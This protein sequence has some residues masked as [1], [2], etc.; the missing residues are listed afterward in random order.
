MAK[1]PTPHGF[2][3][4]EEY[5]GYMTCLS[6]SQS[7]DKAW[8]YTTIPYRAPSPHITAI[9]REVVICGKRM[10]NGKTT[11]KFDQLLLLGSN[12]CQG[13][14]DMK[15]ERE[16][17]YGINEGHTVDITM[18]RQFKYGYWSTIGDVRIAKIIR[19]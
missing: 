7:G 5:E 14:W 11:S 1:R 9:T 13:F 12:E 19:R 17:W 16:E 3:S 18:M 8:I 15:N 4:F 2:K 10:D 6:K